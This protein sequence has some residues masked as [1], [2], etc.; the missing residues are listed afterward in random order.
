[1]SKSLG[2]TV[3]PWQVTERH[4]A[5]AMRWY[6]FTSRQPWAGYRFSLGTIEEAV[7]QFLLPL[8]NTYYFYLLYARANGIG[9]KA[10]ASAEPT[11]ELDRWASSRLQATIADVRAALDSYDATSGGRSLAAYVDELSNWYVRRSR[12]RFWDGDQAAFATLERCLVAV[13]KLLAPFCPFVADEIY[14]NLDGS[15]ASVHL[16]DFPEASARDTELEQGMATA[17]ETVRLGLAARAQARLKIR[18]PLRAAVIVASGRERDAIERLAKLV[19][20]E[21]NVHE[22]R[23]VTA[24]DELSTVEVKPNYR[25]LGPRFGRQMPTVAA[26]VAGLDGAHVATAV[27]D[28][29]PVAISVDGHDH[30]LEPAD[31][32]LALKPLEGYQ[33]EREGSHAVALELSVDDE[34]RAEG[35]AREIVHTVQAA[36]R[37][38][39]L[40]VSDRITLAFDGDDELLAAAQAH[41]PYI[42]RETLA[43][44][45]QYAPAGPDGASVCGPDG[46]SVWIDGRELR[47]RLTRAQG[48]AQA[49]PSAGG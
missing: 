42:A 37:E 12:R 31:L 1:M 23:F 11:T 49:G 19:R 28:G 15:A 6:L 20:E 43:V 27:R 40:D 9:P 33:V 2:N 17:R 3:D 45:V 4:G 25:T 8:W 26:A 30:E 29:R 13:A 41:Q 16:T 18:Q 7:R 5:D 35:W 38:A 46:A 44:E 34:L 47:L 36:R 14:D 39:G 10:V 21:L 32:L 24:A 22:L 48:A